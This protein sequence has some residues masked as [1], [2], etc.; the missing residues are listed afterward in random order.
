ML[1]AICASG[2]LA[3]DPVVS[4]TVTKWAIPPLA[5]EDFQITETG[6]G[7]INVT[8]TKGTAA[9]ITIIRMSTAG[10]PFSIYDGTDVYSGNGTYVE[11]SDLALGTYTYY[12]RAW[13]QNEYGTSTGYAQAS[14]GTGATTSADM[15]ELIDYLETLFGGPMGISSMVF[16]IALVGFGFW[17]KGWIRVLVAICIIVWGAFAMDYDIKVAAPLIAIGS[18]LFFMGTLK[19]IANYRAAREEG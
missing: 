4:I 14:V 9:N 11:V 16:A 13:S 15:S 5:P 6:V 12:F 1:L 8:W 2:A 18:V 17:K 10:Y 7:S 19:L 3:A